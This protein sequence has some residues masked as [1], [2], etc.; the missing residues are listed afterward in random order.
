MPQTE[1]GYE[2]CLM[3]T[4]FHRS[5][6]STPAF[7]TRPIMCQFAFCH[8]SYWWSAM[9]R[10]QMSR[11]LTSCPKADNN[12]K[13]VHSAYIIHL[14]LSRHVGILSSPIIPRREYHTVAILR[15][16]SH[17]LSFITAYCYH[18]PI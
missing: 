1:E 9:I 7:C 15:E 14:I 2:S 12:L 8:F 17:S 10:K 6:A 18:C 5:V 11:L 4:W 3:V 13:L 16:K